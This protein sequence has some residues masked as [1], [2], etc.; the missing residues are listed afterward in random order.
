MLRGFIQGGIRFPGAAARRRPPAR[1]THLGRALPQCLRDPSPAALLRPAPARGA[2]A[3]SSSSAF[4]RLGEDALAHVLEGVLQRFRDHLSTASSRHIDRA[5]H[6]HHLFCARFRIAREHM[7]D[8]VGVDLKLHAD[9][10]L[11][12]RSALEIELSN[13]PSAQLSRAISRSPCSTLISID[14]LPGHG[15]GEHLPGLDRDR[16]YCAE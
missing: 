5:R 11:T 16:R 15:V 10:R 6:L 4:S 14:S 8:A 13:S 9:A 3:G 2:P 12:F 1:L 7:Q